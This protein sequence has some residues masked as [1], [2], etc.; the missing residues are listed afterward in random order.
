VQQVIVRPSIFN[1]VELK[2]NTALQRDTIYHVSVKNIYWCAGNSHDEQRVSVG[3]PGELQPN[4]IIINEILFNPRN[5]G[6][7]YVE[8]YNRSGKI[9]D[10]SSLYLSNRNSFIQICTTSFYSFPGD[11]FVIKENAARLQL[12]YFVKN[13]DAVI[14]IKNMPSFPDDKGNVVLMNL[15][16]III[17]EV[18]YDEKWHF[19]LITDKEGVAL[20]RIDANA[21]SQNAANWHSAAADA[22]Y[23]TPGYK[24]S[25]SAPSLTGATIEIVPKVI[26]PDNDGHDDFAVVQYHVAAPGYAANVQVFDAAGR[27]VRYLVKNAIMGENGYWTWD[28]LD[29][30]GNSLPIGLYIIYTEIF[31]LQGKKQRFKNTVILAKRF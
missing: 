17:D 12:D 20:E 4:D 21:V 23:G 19:K 15:Q 10:L 28:G 14:E 24:N 13:P 27:P 9:I 16:T 25:Q 8:I 11:Y 7:D 26:S 5:P 18:D 22:G 30:K 31:N 29:E 1:T 6:T 2:L 3:L